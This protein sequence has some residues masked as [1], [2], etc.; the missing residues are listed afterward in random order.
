MRTG[1]ELVLLGP[2]DPQP[3]VVPL[4]AQPHHHL[5]ERAEQSVV[6]GGVHQ[7]GVAVTDALAQG[8]Q[9]VRRACHRLHATGDDDVELAARDV[10]VGQRDRVQTGEADLV[11]RDRGHA[12]R[13]SAPDRGLPSGDLALASLDHVTHDHI[14]DLLAANARARQ[15]GF[16]REPAELDGGEGLQ[17]AGQLADRGPRAG[18]DDGTRHGWPPGRRLRVLQQ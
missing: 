5:I 4:G 11:H 13:D 12:H 2:A 15:G 14:I 1:G 6:G 16:D 18:H 8:R 3:R 17:S 9:Q 10:G 7:F